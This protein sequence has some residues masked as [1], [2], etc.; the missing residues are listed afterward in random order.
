M[1]RRVNSNIIDLNYKPKDVHRR[2]MSNSDFKIAQLSVGL[3][4]SSN[5]YHK[6]SLILPDSLNS[7]A[8][9]PHVQSDEIKFTDILDTSIRH[10][11]SINPVCSSL[12]Q[13]S[14][15][16]SQIASASHAIE[17]LR[18]VKQG[19]H[20]K[21]SSLGSKNREFEQEN[22]KLEE[23]VGSLKNHLDRV[24][25]SVQRAENELKNLKTKNSGIE[26]GGVIRRDMRSN[27]YMK[28]GFGHS[29]NDEFEVF[30]AEE[31]SC[32]VFA[33]PF[34]FANPSPKVQGKS[35]YSRSSRK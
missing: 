10:F 8:I 25:V 27:T 35:L 5:F 2:T 12:K 15:L 33:D 3:A 1:H 26:V 18:Q 28:D 32:T 16:K 30:N 4:A 34:Q 22:E 29:S 13:I 14:D 17:N 11:T 24:K 7:S 31:N 6:P 20:N 9:Q 19:L 23:Y 21:L